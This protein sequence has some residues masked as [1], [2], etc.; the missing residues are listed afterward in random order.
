MNEDGNS[1]L[2]KYFKAQV[3][4]PV[5]GDFVTMVADDM[6]V[7]EL[8]QCILKTNENAGSEG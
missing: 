2:K 7:L 8:L 6:K 4:F 1:L 3:E 5:K